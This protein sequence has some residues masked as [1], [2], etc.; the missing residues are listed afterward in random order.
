LG[1]AHPAVWAVRPAPHL[2]DNRRAVTDPLPPFRVRISPPELRDALVDALVAGDCL[3]ARLP[4]DTVLVV[5]RDAADKAEARVEL[6]FF[7]RAWAAL[8]THAQAEFV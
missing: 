5:H 8:H 4:D 1:T 7:L 3:C 2:P 6:G